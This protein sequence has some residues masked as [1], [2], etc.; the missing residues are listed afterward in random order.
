MGILD[1]FR[2][3]KKSFSLAQIVDLSE[4]CDC[5]IGPLIAR[6]ADYYEQHV[7]VWNLDDPVLR[8]FVGYLAGVVD[9]AHLVIQ[10]NPEPKHDK[11]LVELVLAHMLKKHAPWVDRVGAICDD[12]IKYQLEVGT[13]SVLVGG[14]ID[15]PKATAAMACGAQDFLALAVGGVRT[16]HRLR[17]VVAESVPCQAMNQ[18]TAFWED[19]SRA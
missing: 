17:D 9:A 10:D 8:A 14:L 1:I 16:A 11:R 2:R 6:D 4:V 15:N 19:A 18:R 5:F 12:V 13:G 3:K 7:R